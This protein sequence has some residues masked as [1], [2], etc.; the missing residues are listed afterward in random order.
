[1]RAQARRLWVLASHEPLSWHSWE[2]QHRSRA[3]AVQPQTCVLSIALEHVVELLEE[4]RWMALVPHRVFL[5]EIKDLG[6]VRPQTPVVGAA[7]C[8]PPLARRAFPSRPPKFSFL[9]LSG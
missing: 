2:L 1:M 5:S 6:C 8:A 3:D 7:A 9:W 4:T